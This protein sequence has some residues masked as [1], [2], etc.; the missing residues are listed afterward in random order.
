LLPDD[1]AL[2]LTLQL[3]IGA[4]SYA[5]ARSTME[6]LQRRGTHIGPE[7]VQMFERLSS[8]TAQTEVP[9]D[10]EDIVRSETFLAS[11]IQ[12]YSDKELRGFIEMVEKWDRKEMKGFELVKTSNALLSC[13]RNK[14]GVSYRNTVDRIFFRLVQMNK[15]DS[16]SFSYYFD[17]ITRIQDPRATAQCLSSFRVW[18]CRTPLVSPELVSKY[19]SISQM[20]S[21]QCALKSWEFIPKSVA[22]SAE[23]YL[24]Y[25]D[26]CL[27]CHQLKKA[28][29]ALHKYGLAHPGLKSRAM[30][31]IVSHLSE[32]APVKAAR[33]LHR[34]LEKE[35][36]IE[37]S[38][39]M[40]I[41][42]LVQILLSRR[43]PF[44]ALEVIKALEN[45]ESI[46]SVEQ[47]IGK[48]LFDQ[49]YSLLNQFTR[50]KQTFSALLQ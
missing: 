20:I 37:D 41:I 30:D 16:N 39:R 19:L 9:D 1:E 46:A 8:E 21:P 5:L 36:R 4:K 24:T 26:L 44:G 22:L 35:D 2:L 7:Q 47:F 6:Q 48:D 3:A 13:L 32:D 15:A 23:D 49:I 33:F 14:V 31:K 34:V 38:F 17:C 28:I 12:G 42:K 10:L 40:S 29:K 50:L 45:V 43:E 18:L 25:I 27:T 11:L